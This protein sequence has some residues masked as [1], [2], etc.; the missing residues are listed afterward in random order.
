MS[1]E[2][3]GLSSYPLKIHSHAVLCSSW[4]VSPNVFLQSPIFSRFLYSELL[5]TT[6]IRTYWGLTSSI[7]ANSYSKTCRVT[8]LTNMSHGGS[9]R[10]RLALQ[11]T[12]TIH[13]TKTA[14]QEILWCN[15]NV[16][17]TFLRLKTAG[18]SLISLITVYAITYVILKNTEM[19]VGQQ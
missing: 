10:E 6:V 1:D 15:C 4:R 16:S 9:H 14:H 11:R 18:E 8:L 17:G 13:T 7:W 2:T 3:Q 5:L 19:S 12:N